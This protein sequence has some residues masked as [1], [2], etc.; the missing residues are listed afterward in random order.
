MKTGIY[1]QDPKYAVGRNFSDPGCVLYL[2]LHRL[3]GAS[4]M[5]KDAYGHLCT[6][7]GALWTPQGRSFDGSDDLIDCGNP[8]VLGE[9][10]FMWWMKTSHDWAAY[11]GIFD[12]SSGATYQGFHMTNQSRELYLR[13]NS[14]N[15]CR[16]SGVP[17]DLSGWHH[18]A[19]YIAGGGQNDIDNA[20]LRID[21]TD[22]PP[23]TVVKTNAPLAWDKFILGMS[24]YGFLECTIDEVRIYKRGLTP[25]EKQHHY[26]AAKWRYR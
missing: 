25:L 17:A 15:R 9:T 6:A 23:D 20:T 11:G 4:F 16:F 10:T 2:P 18:Y 22:Y 7:T 24:D 26:L 21:E 3:D 13:L 8:V 14:S 12:L 19:L 5:S 1:W